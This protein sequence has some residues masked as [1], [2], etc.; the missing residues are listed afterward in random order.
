MDPPQRVS[1]VYVLCLLK[2]R[3]R[4][5]INPLDVSQWRFFVV[6]KE[7]LDV[8]LGEMRTVSLKR[9]NEFEERV[10]PWAYA[11]LERKI[12]NCRKP[13]S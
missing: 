8:E 7:R 12:R 5:N 1:D 2:E 4:R 11:D 9:L 10:G 6:L 3:D 13:S